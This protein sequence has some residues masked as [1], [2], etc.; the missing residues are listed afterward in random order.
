MW[1]SDSSSDVSLPLCP[2]DTVATVGDTV[3]LRAAQPGSE[4][5][6]WYRRPVGGR[7]TTIYTG[8]EVDYKQVDHRYIGIP[9]NLAAFL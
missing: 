4:V 5:M 6:R 2:T 3:A 1:S 7:R 9:V 8:L